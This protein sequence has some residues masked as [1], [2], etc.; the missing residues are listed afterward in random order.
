L[1]LQFQIPWPPIVESLL[2]TSDVMSNVD[3]QSIPSLTCILPTFQSRAML[4]LLLPVFVLFVIAVLSKWRTPKG[5]H[6]FFTPAS[7]VALSLLYTQLLK[8]TFMLFA[9]R[10]L[11]GEPGKLF[12]RE[13]V[14]MVCYEDEHLFWMFGLGLPALLLVVLGF[15]L[16][17][18]H[19]L[20]TRRY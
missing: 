2:K 5:M 16:A 11:L 12:L 4:M 3:P 18:I 17:K 15:P 14:A 19:A 20:Y 8:N 13:D 9:C 10:T 1:Q 6:G 7:L